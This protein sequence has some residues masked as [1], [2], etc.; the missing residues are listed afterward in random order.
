VHN[1][2]IALEKGG[3]NW[4]R[5]TFFNCLCLALG[6]RVHNSEATMPYKIHHVQAPYQEGFR[7]PKEARCSLV[8]YFGKLPK[9]QPPKDA[10][11]NRKLHAE[12]PVPTK[13]PVT[14]KPSNKKRGSYTKWADPHNCEA[15][16][17]AMKDHTEENMTT[18]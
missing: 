7:E 11:I 3:K 10:I 18:A 5:E 14:T 9:G 1:I 16:R 6:F 4:G 8:G 2:L 15:L 12:P 13:P 17:A